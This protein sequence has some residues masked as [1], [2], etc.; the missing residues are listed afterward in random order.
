VIIPQRAGLTSQMQESVKMKKVVE[1]AVI[2]TEV[3]IEIGTGVIEGGALGNI[4]IAVIVIEAVGI[5][6]DP[7]VE[8]DEKEATK[9]IVEGIVQEEEK[10][11]TQGKKIETVIIMLVVVVAV[12]VEAEI[13]DQIGVKNEM[14]AADGVKEAAEDQIT[15]ILAITKKQITKI[16]VGKQDW[17]CG[18]LI[19]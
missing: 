1:R 9:G 3:E 10:W 5:D 6:E 18:N 12:A 19:I 2:E 11:G 4:E 14:K 8:T 17:S 15:T 7:E 16:R 13:E